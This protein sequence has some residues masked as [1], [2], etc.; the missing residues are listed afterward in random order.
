MTVVQWES[1]STILAFEYLFMSLVALF[2]VL[3][4]LYYRHRRVSYQMAIL[5]GCLSMGLLRFLFFLFLNN[6]GTSL[7]FQFFL[8]APSLLQFITFSLF[9]LYYA[10][11]L[12]KSNWSQKWKIIVAIYLL[13]NLAFLMFIVFYVGMSYYYYDVKGEDSGWLLWLQGYFNGTI[14]L[15]L[16]IILAAY[17]YRVFRLVQQNEIEIPFQLRATANKF[18]LLIVV[19]IELIFISR[20]LYDFIMPMS[21]YPIPL[22]TGMD[23]GDFAML[24]VY[25]IWEIIPAF[26]IIFLFS[27]NIGRKGKKSMPKKTNAAPL[28]EE[29][30]NSDE[31]GIFSNDLRYDSDEGIGIKFSPPSYHDPRT[32]ST[33]YATT[34]NSHV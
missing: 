7:L 8:W 3:R 1:A 33:P 11:Q 4:I 13:C 15:V 16:V 2:Q 5:L 21:R 9:V 31:S 30:I 25:T 32:F 12:H 23:S 6:W 17:A 18:V 27:W 34:P 22:E 10:H 20:S 24:A 14:F 28:L 29:E 19:I 26:L